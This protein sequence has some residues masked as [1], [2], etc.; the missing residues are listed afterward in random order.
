G[1]GGRDAGHRVGPRPGHLSA[2]RD[3]ISLGRCRMTEV[4]KTS[5]LLVEDHAVVR[6]SL[7]RLLET[8]GHCGVVGQAKNGRE[9]VEMA[10]KLNPDVILMDIA[11]PVLNGHGA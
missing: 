4:K 10:A 1:N 8:E 6:Q 2:G 9:A 5:V 3:P 11:M 7:C